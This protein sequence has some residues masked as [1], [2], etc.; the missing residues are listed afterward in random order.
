[1][2]ERKNPD[3][4]S[5]TE[6]VYKAY[7]FS[8][9]VRVGDLYF[10][11]GLAPVAGDLQTFHLVGEGD[12]KVQLEMC[13]RILDELLAHEDLDRSNVVSWTM[14]TTDMPALCA[15][16]GPIIADWVG[17]HAPANTMVTVSGFVTPGQLIEITPIAVRN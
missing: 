4:H 9:T 14:Y 10:F 12:M 16:M 5:I 6:E 7:S 2:I 8:Q 15:V 1:M 13:L 3:T 17:D 11:A